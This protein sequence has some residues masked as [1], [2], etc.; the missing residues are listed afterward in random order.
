M[1]EGSANVKCGGKL[2]NGKPCGRAAGWGTP[3][4]G[5]GRCKIH[6]GSTPSQVKH[7]GM[8]MAEQL[9][10]K[11]SHQIE[12]TPQ[13]AM[14]WMVRAK[15]GEVLYYT[16]RIEEMEAEGR[17][18]FAT[19]V[20]TL[21]RPLDMGK[22]GEDPAITVTETSRSNDVD[23]VHWVRQREVAMRDLA[24]FSQM[25]MAAGIE[26][27]RVHLEEQQGERFAIIMHDVLTELGLG[28][29]PA[30][31]PIVTKHLKQL[32]SLDTIEGKAL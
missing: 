7:V 17:A 15:A 30:V 5:V 13:E 20:S 28:K 18:L 25:A 24:K 22:E 12:V 9:A 26:E 2:R 31:V 21:E 29:D 4:P 27:R 16:Q 14:L 3:H 11:F 19:K 32:N 1:T 6:G 8:K 10:I 23:M